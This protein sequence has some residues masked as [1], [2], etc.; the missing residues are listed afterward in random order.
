[1]INNVISREFNIDTAYVEVKLSNDSMVSIDCIAVE[2]ENELMSYVRLLFSGKIE[3]YVRNIA[4]LYAVIRYDITSQK[5]SHTVYCIV[6][7]M[8]VFYVF[9]IKQIV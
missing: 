1:M 3:D 6:N 9:S 8:A 2:H 5:Y 7:C 4:R